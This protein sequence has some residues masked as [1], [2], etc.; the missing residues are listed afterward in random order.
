MMKPH[1][2]LIA[3][4]LLAA[5][6]ATTAV[7]ES[8]VRS[9]L[10]D[11]GVRPALASCMARPMAEQLSVEQLR[12]LQAVRGI[13]RAPMRDITMG[14]VYDLMRRS[15]DPETMSVVTRAGLGCA[16]TG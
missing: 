2:L 3:L 11:A 14:E 15:V 6:C 16:I 13:T 8:R 1:C 4:P 9:A 10:V 12:R 7:K 5:A